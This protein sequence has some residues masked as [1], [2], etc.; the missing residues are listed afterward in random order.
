[1]SECEKIKGMKTSRIFWDFKIKLL[2]KK[3]MLIMEFGNLVSY[4][5]DQYMS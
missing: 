3:K 1:M 5:Q 2:E 4:P